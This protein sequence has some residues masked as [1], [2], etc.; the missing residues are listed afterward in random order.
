M[1]VTKSTLK[2]AVYKLFYNC[3][4]DNYPNPHSSRYLV[5]PS[6]PIDKVTDRNAY[7][8]LIVD[9]PFFD[10]DE[11]TF[12]ETEYHC[13]LDLTFYS[14][15]KKDLDDLVQDIIKIIEDQTKKIFEA[16]GV[17]FLKITSDGGD[18]FNHGSDRGNNAVLGHSE[19]VTFDMK[20]YL[21][22]ITT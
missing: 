7:P 3:I 12:R 21:E 11:F 18:P 22:R 10:E 8:M 1:V 6:F 20:I 17:E 2:S 14:L 13:E 4:V 9:S 15:S 19:T 5:Y 16:N